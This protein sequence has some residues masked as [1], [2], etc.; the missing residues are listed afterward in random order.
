MLR[1]FGT[2]AVAA[3]VW[4]AAL[5]LPAAVHA[6]DGPAAAATASQAVKARAEF[7][8]PKVKRPRKASIQQM[9]RVAS[10]AAPAPY[11]PQCFIFWCSSGG[12]SFNFLMLGVAY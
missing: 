12:R 8:T 4:A 11:H 2:V 5:A 7:A 1:S 6:K 10:V 3:S 9:R